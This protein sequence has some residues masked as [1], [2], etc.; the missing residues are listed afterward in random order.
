MLVI[1]RSGKSRRKLISI[2]RSS[3]L[4]LLENPSFELRTRRSYVHEVFRHLAW[5]KSCEVTLHGQNKI[6]LHMLIRAL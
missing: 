3:C 4:V 6:I 5:Y 2:L 1:G